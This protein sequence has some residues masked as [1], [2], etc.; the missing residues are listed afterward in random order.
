MPSGGT[1]ATPTPTPEPTP[2]PTPE[3]AIGAACHNVPDGSGSGSGCA[4]RGAARFLPALEAAVERARGATYDDPGSGQTVDMVAGDGLVIAARAYIQFI[5]DEL[6]AEGMCGVFDGEEIQIR[7]TGAD[8][9]NFDVI[10]SSG[11]AWSNYVVTCAPALPIPSPPPTPAA[12]SDPNCALPPSLPFLCV[13][14]TAALDGEV[15]AAQDALIARDQAESTAKIFDFRDRIGGT[16]YGY[17][18]IDDQ[19]YIAGMLE[20][21]RGRGLCANFDGEEFNV[22]QG[23]NIFSENYDMTK[24]DGFAIRIYNATCRDASF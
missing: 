12:T 10:T 1:P 23:T 16:T 4:R 19:A 14:Q 6:D 8:N 11:F 5:I 24:Q 18:I 3:P 17:R 21:L 22:K 2:D 15:Y 20:E 7:D 13:R 9:E